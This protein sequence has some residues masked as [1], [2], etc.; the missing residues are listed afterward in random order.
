LESLAR[1]RTPK[2]MATPTRVMMAHTMASHRHRRTSSTTI[3]NP[4]HPKAAPRHTTTMAQAQR[5]RHRSTAT[6][7]HLNRRNMDRPHTEPPHHTARKI[8]RRTQTTAVVTASTSN[9]MPRT[10]PRVPPSSSSSSST[11]RHSL[12]VPTERCRTSRRRMGRRTDVG[13]HHVVGVACLDKKT[14]LA[15]G[16]GGGGCWLG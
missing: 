10:R 1:D 14:V 15:W 7:R 3:S 4:R 11:C 2:A 12:R 16:V 9:R 5:T 13:A 8:P 6:T